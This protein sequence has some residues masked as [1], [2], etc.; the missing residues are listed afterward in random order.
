MAPGALSQAIQGLES[1][2]RQPLFYGTTCWVALAEAGERLLGRRARV[3]T[4]SLDD[5]P[6]MGA[7]RI[8]ECLSQG[9]QGAVRHFVI[10][11]SRRAAIQLIRTQNRFQCDIGRI[12]SALLGETAQP[13]RYTDFRLM[14]VR[15]RTDLTGKK[16]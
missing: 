2:L 1:R 4:G 3:I 12:A 15:W 9:A 6:Q 10:R 16:P 11:Q 8:G 14:S 5:L 7:R 13:G